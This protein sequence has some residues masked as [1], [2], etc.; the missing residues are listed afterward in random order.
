MI[1]QGNEIQNLML[2]C[3]LIT[4]VLP[5]N[6]EESMH[7][8]SKK[9]KKRPAEIRIWV[10]A[11]LVTHASIL[12]AQENV[13]LMDGKQCGFVGCMWKFLLHA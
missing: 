11:H 8:R 12:C 9:N 6:S 1:P 4:E 2:Q 7:I 10:G 5:V 3:N 13:G